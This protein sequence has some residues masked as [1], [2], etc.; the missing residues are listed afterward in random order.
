[1]LISNPIMDFLLIILA[2]SV[3]GIIVIKI[4]NATFKEVI[5]FIIS[6]LVFVAVV[7]V[8]VKMII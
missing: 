8:I 5:K 2:A 1:M 6:V 3:I 7:W 4:V